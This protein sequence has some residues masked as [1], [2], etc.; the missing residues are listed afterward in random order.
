MFSLRE[1]VF[2]WFLVLLLRDEEIKE[3]IERQKD[4]LR[5]EFLGK[6]ASWSWLKDS[7]HKVDLVQVILQ[8]V[9]RLRRTGLTVWDLFEVPKRDREF[10]RILEFFG[11]DAL[12]S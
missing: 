3:K 4:I 10:R 7:R 12:S 8:G 5:R 11:T 1:N 6:D 9:W 2:R